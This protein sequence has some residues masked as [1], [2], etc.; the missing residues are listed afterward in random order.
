MAGDS[1]RLLYWKVR[2]RRSNPAQ[3]PGRT[4]QRRLTLRSGVHRGQACDDV[5]GMAIERLTPS[6][7]APP[8]LG[9]PSF[10]GP[11]PRNAGGMPSR[12]RR[13]EPA[14]RPPVGEH[15]GWAFAPARITEMCKPKVMSAGGEL[16]NDLVAR[17]YGSILPVGTEGLGASVVVRA[18][19]RERHRRSS[20][21]AAS[22]RSMPIIWSQERAAK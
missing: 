2:C 6:L 1:G 4:A 3:M 15:A 20:P 7:A 10:A 19:V 13:P 9:R 12:S 8:R 18:V 22:T 16:R 21:I 11:S 17:A 5:N 14:A